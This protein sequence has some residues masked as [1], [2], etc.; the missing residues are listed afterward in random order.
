MPDLPTHIEGLLAAY[1]AEVANGW[2]DE[3]ETWLRAIL[4]AAWEMAENQ[5]SGEHLWGGGSYCGSCGSDIGKPCNPDC[6]HR[7]LK[8]VMNNA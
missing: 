5:P 2:G 8:E 3:A 4:G 1:D 6:P 7:K